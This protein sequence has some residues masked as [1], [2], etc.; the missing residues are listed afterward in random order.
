M[1]TQTTLPAYSA[2]VTKPIT[3]VQ[4][5]ETQVQI[6]APTFTHGPPPTY[7]TVQTSEP[8]PEK[9]PESTP[10]PEPTKAPLGILSIIGAGFVLMVLIKP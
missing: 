5:V 1:V 4:T 9:T 10:V 6:S 7:K 2:T 3:P 8:T